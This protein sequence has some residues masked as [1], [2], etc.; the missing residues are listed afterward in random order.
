MANGN[1]DGAAFSALGGP[2]GTSARIRLRRTRWLVGPLAIGA[3]I[4]GIV[5]G[6]ASAQA[7][8][9]TFYGRGDGH[10]IGMSQWGAEGAAQQGWGAS[11]ILEWFYRGTSITKVPTASIRVL[12]AGYAS[13]FGIGVNGTGQLVDSA[14][15]ARKTLSS[16]VDY[17]VRPSGAGVVV[18]TPTGALIDRAPKGVRVLPV[19]SGLVDFDGRPYRG[20]LSV[21]AAGGTINAI[22]T[23]PLEA[24]LRGVVPSEM[25]SSWAPAALQAQAIAAR[26]YALHAL[27]SSASFDVYPDAR[28]QVYGGVDAEAATTNAA[29]SATADQAVTYHGTVVAAFFAAS[30]GGYTE[31]VQNVWGGLGEPYLVGVPDPFDAIAPSHIWQHPPKFTGAQLGALLGTGGTVTKVDVLKRGVS[32]RVMLARVS[33]ASGASVEMTGSDIEAYLGLDSTWFWVGQ[34]NQPTPKQPPIGGSPT[35]N[36]TPTVAHTRA[37]SY[38]VVVSNSSHAAASRRLLTRIKHIAP[39]E[40]LITRGTGSHR[41]YLVVAI[42]VNTSAAVTKARVALRK[43]GYTSVVMRAIAG[44]PAPRPAITQTIAA[45]PAPPPKPAAPVGGLVPPTSSGLPAGAAPP[46]GP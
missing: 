7:I 28:S 35:P 21:T 24:Y 20:S 40:Q 13:Q 36:P 23:V 16:G 31:D 30:D 12:L 8:T 1:P 18:T 17:V 39:G 6:P 43:F 29:I 45:Y 9:F 22:N 10:G 5:A 27:D 19:G 46:P 32:P 34:S 2:S 41:R 44:D 4:A 3:C 26:S 11:R 25:P 42:R 37:G 14:T 38:L 15:G 33:L